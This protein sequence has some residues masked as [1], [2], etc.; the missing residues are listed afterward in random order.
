MAE[1]FTVDAARALITEVAART[2]QIIQVRADLA[3]LAS[4]LH[5]GGESDIGGIPEAKAYEARLDELVSWFA[6]QGIQV[7][8]LAPVLIDF[9]AELDGEHVLLCWLEGEAELAWYHRPDLGFVARR[10][11]PDRTGELG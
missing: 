6:E 3:E 7:K 2:R 4:D 10:P 8:G 1:L 5:A 9:P 11:L